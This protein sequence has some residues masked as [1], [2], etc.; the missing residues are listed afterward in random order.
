MLVTRFQNLAGLGNR[1]M[2]GDTEQTQ[3]GSQTSTYDP[4]QQDFY[5]K[6]LN[7]ANDWL[8]QGGINQGT[9]YTSQLQ[10]NLDN[11]AAFYQNAMNQGV[12][13]QALQG[14]MDSY[15]QAATQNFQRNVIPTLQAQSN[16][17][18]TTNSSRTGI[19]EGLAASDLNQQIVNQNAQLAWNAEQDALN[20]QMQAAQGYNSLLGQQ[21]SIA[22]YQNRYNNTGLESLLAY[23]QLI[24]GNMGGTESGSSTGSAVGE[25]GGGLF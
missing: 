17:S 16:M 4:A 24:S 19:A 13:Q 21:M 14:A 10:G 11:T 23:K 3:S 12:N 6:L 18:G 22:D 2:K 20:R 25:G 5:D 15:S 7:Q 8:N 9:D 1:L